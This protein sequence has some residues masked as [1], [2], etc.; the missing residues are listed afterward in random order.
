ML[1]AQRAVSSAVAVL[2][3]GAPD[4]DALLPELARVDREMADKAA[5]LEEL[6][7][8][9][10]ADAKLGE[11]TR[12]SLELLKLAESRLELVAKGSARGDGGGK[13]AAAGAATEAGLAVTELGQLAAARLRAARELSKAGSSAKGGG[14][15]GKAAATAAPSAKDQEDALARQAA[16]LAAQVRVN[17]CVCFFRHSARVRLCLPQANPSPAMEPRQRKSGTWGGDP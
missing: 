8:A 5:R 16:A 11:R 3:E 13:G 4:A 15:K 14:T 2:K 12:A 17:V 6:E 7:A 9:P 1:A 10:G